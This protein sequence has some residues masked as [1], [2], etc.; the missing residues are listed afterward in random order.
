VCS[1]LPGY[2][3]VTGLGSPARG[4]DLVLRDAP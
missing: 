3:T 1:A 4:L 2:D